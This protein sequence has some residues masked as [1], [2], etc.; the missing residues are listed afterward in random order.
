MRLVWGTV[1]AVVGEEPGL[2]RLEVAL[3]QG[4]GPALCYPHLSGA[5]AVGERVL[6]N[7]TAV[8]L[9]LGTG[10]VHFVVARETADAALDEA[11]DG[12]IMKLRYTPLQLDVASVE[13]QHSPHHAVMRDATDLGGMPV[14]CCGLHSQLPLVAAAVKTRGAG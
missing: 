9:A 5:C 14:V 10:G 2:Q 7:T 11:S 13:E 6:L 1:S 4:T 8:D 3:R 12:R